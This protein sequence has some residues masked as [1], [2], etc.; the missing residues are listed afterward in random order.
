[1]TTEQIKSALHSQVDGL[2]FD[3]ARELWRSLEENCNGTIVFVPEIVRSTW[4]L[5]QQL[6]DAHARE[7]EQLEDIA[8]LGKKLATGG[9]R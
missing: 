2:T 1:M 7:H 9:L 5:R 3:E 6:D 8:M 4:S